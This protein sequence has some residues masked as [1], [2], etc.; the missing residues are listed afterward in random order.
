MGEQTGLVLTRRRFMAKG[1]QSTGL[2][3]GAML[4]RSRYQKVNR[5]EAVDFGVKRYWTGK[6]CVNGHTDY[7]YTS[8]GNC[9]AC[10]DNTLRRIQ[11]K[12][13]YGTPKMVEIDAINAERELQKELED[14]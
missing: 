11:A 8:T 3:F 2:E 5:Q 10:Q 7:R 9:S 4:R 1:R 14:Y 12:K 6:P 13:E